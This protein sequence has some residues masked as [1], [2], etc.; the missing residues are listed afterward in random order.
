MKPILILANKLSRNRFGLCLCESKSMAKVDH[1][2]NAP[3]NPAPISALTSGPVLLTNPSKKDPAAF[4]IKIP[5]GNSN[6]LLK[7]WSTTYRNGEPSPA[8][9]T[10]INILIAMPAYELFAVALVILKQLRLHKTQP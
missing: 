10:T 9:S 6:R 1:V 4:T 2:V 3:E 7:A 5:R 8:P